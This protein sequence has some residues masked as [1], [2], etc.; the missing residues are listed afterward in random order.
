[1]I[2]KLRSEVMSRSQIPKGQARAR[3]LVDI[4]KNGRSL[5][6]LMDQKLNTGISAP[7]MGRAAMTANSAARLSLKFGLPIIPCGI[8]RTNGAQFKFYVR[9][10][11]KFAPSDDLTADIF[12]LTCKINEALEREINAQPDQ[13]LWLHRRWPNESA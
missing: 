4:I 11:I 3:A 1:L 10:P 2:I 12:D 13:W 8:R 6:M 9:D 7:F 5:G